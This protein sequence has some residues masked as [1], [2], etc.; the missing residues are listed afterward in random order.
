MALLCIFIRLQQEY[1]TILELNIVLSKNCRIFYPWVL[2]SSRSFTGHTSNW[3]NSEFVIFLYIIV[4]FKIFYSFLGHDQYIVV[5][6]QGHELPRCHVASVPNLRYMSMGMELFKCLEVLV[7]SKLNLT[8][9]STITSIKIITLGQQDSLYYCSGGGGF[10][11]TRYDFYC[12]LNCS[13]S[14]IL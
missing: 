3:R 10:L 14:D 2:Q 8:C 7:P 12:L 6:G 9:P 5:N 13:K 1:V 11:Y 4:K